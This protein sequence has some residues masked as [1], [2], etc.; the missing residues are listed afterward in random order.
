MA[1]NGVSALVLGHGSNV[2]ILEVVLRNK[3]QTGAGVEKES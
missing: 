1:L 3:M 2:L